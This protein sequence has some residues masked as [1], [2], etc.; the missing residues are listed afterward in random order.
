SV[1]IIALLSIGCIAHV[2]VPP[3][4]TRRE[5]GDAGSKYRSVHR[6]PKAHVPSGTTPFLRE[7]PTPDLCL[8]PPHEEGHPPVLPRFAP[9]RRASGMCVVSEGPPRAHRGSIG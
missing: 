3:L 1:T 2:L 6:T 4:C 7:V 8:S 5:R 9:L